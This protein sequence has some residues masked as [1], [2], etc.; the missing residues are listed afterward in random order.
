MAV[1]RAD[2]E[3]FSAV[4]GP[5]SKRS[6]FGTK[7]DATGE[8]SGGLVAWITAKAA[9]VWSGEAAGASAVAAGR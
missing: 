7:D 8:S 4:S 9:E 5:G 1:D 3:G 2:S 6:L